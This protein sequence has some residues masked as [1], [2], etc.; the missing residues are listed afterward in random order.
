MRGKSIYGI[1]HYSKA[2]EWG[3][4]VSITGSAQVLV[5]GISFIGGILVIRLLPTQEYA[6]YTLA[7]TMLGTMAILADGGISTG[8]ISEGGKVWEDRK[9]LGSVISTGVDLRKIFAIGSLLIATPALLYLLREHGASW[10]MSILIIISLIPAFFTSL[11][12]LLLE[13]APKFHQDL[14]PLQKIQIGTSLGRL[15]LLCLTLFVFPWAYIAILAGGLPQIWANLRLS[16]VSKKY[17]DPEQKA[18]LIVRKNIL[19]MVKR[20]LPDAIFICVSGQLI[21]WLIS[22]FGSTTGV[23]Q[24]GAL[25][26]LAML[27]TIFNTM[28][29]SVILPRFARLPR[30]S[31]LLINRFIQI[32]GGLIVLGIGIIGVV[33]FFAPQILWILGREYQG[34]TTEV[35]LLMIGSVLGFIASSSFILSRSKGWVINPI[36][37]I[38]ISIASIGIGIA[39]VD[40]S[41]LRGI[42]ILNIF[43]SGIQVLMH[44][45]YGLLQILKTRSNKNSIS[46]F[47]I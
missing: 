18:D 19:S 46:S 44:L 2:L 32:H 25:G 15:T 16:K 37:S 36:I 24:V 6:L 42:F 41:S 27:L 4:L 11:T 22:I 28:F 23:A 17:A 45:F 8:V 47:C 43:I 39:F 3:R 20:L 29:A 40:V 1:P 33:W 13:I 12:G 38:P 30:N 5:Q 34:L 26:R 14:F 31:S 7:N 21:I 9:K 35:V 10:T